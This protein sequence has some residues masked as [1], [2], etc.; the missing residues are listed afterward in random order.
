MEFHHIPVLLPEAVDALAIRPDGVYVDGTAGGGGHAAEIARHLTTGKLI[1]V[2]K[3]SEAVETVTRR[4]APYPQAT[5]VRGDFADLPGILHSLSI[6]AADGV[7]LDLGVSSHQLD[8][9]ARGFSYS[10]DAPLDMRMSHEGLTAAELLATADEHTLADIFFRYG[11]EKFAK[12]I[13]RAI[14]TQR[15]KEPIERTGELAGL[16]RET[17][18]AAARREGGHPAKRV[19]QALRIAVNGELDSLATAL[20]NVIQLLAP[21]GRFAVITF[22]SLEDRM[23]KQSFAALVRGCTCPPDFPVCICGKQPR[24]NLITKS[25]IL[26][27]PEEQAQNPR[28]KSAKLRVLEKR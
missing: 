12:K 13:A 23:V 10:T 3:D 1:A 21:G 2:D 7:L 9:A 28:S 22:H 16:I 19:F 8:T 11:E 15:N 25:P 26:P 17:I 24:A 20:E 4:L 6:P 18:P 14:I 5:A 27:L